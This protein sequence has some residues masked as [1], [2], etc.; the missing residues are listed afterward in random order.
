MTAVLIHLSDIHIRS[1]RDPIL[2][3]G[4]AIGRAAYRHLPEATHIFVVV[5]GD[6]AFS[7]KPDQYELATEFLNSLRETMRK[8]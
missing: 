2:E 8:E 4:P 5:T 3:M 6:V 7:G 1:P